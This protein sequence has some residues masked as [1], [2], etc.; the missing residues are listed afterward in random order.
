MV[1]LTRTSEA[2]GLLFALVCGAA[3]A[4][5][6]HLGPPPRD[7][8]SC[9]F[10]SVDTEHRFIVA[11]IME[12]NT[13]TNLQLGDPDGESTVVRVDVEAG[14]NP[15]TVFLHSSDAV[16]W[17]FEGAVGRVKSAIIVA[18]NRQHHSASRGLPD[19]VTKFPDLAGCPQVIGMPSMDPRADKNNVKLY[20]GRDADHITFETKPKA[21]KLPEGEFVSTKERPDKTTH[22]EWELFMYHPGGFRVIDPKSVVSPVLVLEPETHPG[23]AGLLQ[24]ETAGAIRPPER[25]EIDSFFEGLSRR[26]PSKRSEI[27]R[28]RFSVDYVITREIMLPPGMFGAHLKN[29]LVLAGVPELRGNVGHGCLI[30]MDGYRSKDGAVCRGVPRE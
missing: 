14:A 10:A 13:L 7:M 2:A 20:F 21:L 18:R 19:G 9:R 5:Q 22:T 27:E 15:L 11:G 16:I 8:A 29:F 17:D 1:V 30:F 4:R 28:D 25:A 12:G 6:P 3:L 23:E 26:Y 24:L